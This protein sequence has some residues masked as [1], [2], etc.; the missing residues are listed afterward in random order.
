MPL[1]PFGWMT[2]AGL[3]FLFIFSIVIASP[4]VVNGHFAK[5]GNNDDAEIAIK[6]L[7]GLYRFRVKV[8]VI[9]FLGDSVQLKEQVSSTKTGINTWKQFNEEINADDVARAIDRLKDVL[10]M[11]RNLTG[12]ARQTLTKVKMTEWK[13]NTS[14]G[15]GDAMWTAMTTG[16]VWSVKTGVI[17]ILSQMVK[18]KAEPQMAVSPNYEQPY[19][20]TEWSCSAKIRFGHAVLA[21]LKLFIRMRKGKRKKGGGGRMWQN[22]L[23]KV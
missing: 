16:F 12:W 15:T 22:L 13:W 5:S 2:A 17:G 4:V 11:T 6:V 10:E 19:F 7:F 3:F 23:F 20:S 9:K 1:Y 14:V 18:L 8:P 21:G